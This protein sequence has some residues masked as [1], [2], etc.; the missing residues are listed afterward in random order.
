MARRKNVSK[1]AKTDPNPLSRDSSRLIAFDEPS[2]PIEQPLSSRRM[3]RSSVSANTRSYDPPS[4]DTVDFNGTPFSEQSAQSTTS[5][6]RFMSRVSVPAK[7]ADPTTK[8]ASGPKA[9]SRET[10]SVGTSEL[11][12]LRSA[13][14]FSYK[15]MMGDRSSHYE[16]PGTSALATPAETVLKASGTSAEVED[17]SARPKVNAAVRAQELRQSRYALASTSSKRKWEED[18]E[19]ELEESSDHRVARKLQAQLMREANPIQDSVVET[20]T[21]ARARARRSR[22]TKDPAGRRATFGRTYDL[23]SDSSRLSSPES[24]DTEMEDVHTEAVSKRTTRASGASRAAKDSAKKSIAASTSAIIEIGDSDDDNREI[25][26]LDSDEFQAEEAQN[27]EDDE[28]D[29]PT[30]VSVRPVPTSANPTTLTPLQRRMARAAARAARDGSAVAAGAII[31]PI[32]RSRGA[33][34]GH[35]NHIPWRARTTRA[36]R[37]RARLEYYHPEII[38]MWQTLEA[39]PVIPT[40][41]AEQPRYITR[42]LKPFQREGLNWMMQQEKTKWGGGL[43]GDEMGMGKTIQAVSLIMSDYPAKQPTLVVVPPVAL[44]Q[45]KNEIREYTSG[46]LQVLIYHGTQVK[47]VSIKELGRYNVIMTSY[48]T[49]ES[50]YRRQ[51]KGVKRKDEEDPLQTVLVKEDSPF[52]AIQFHRIILDEAHTIKSRQTGT[53]KAC[54]ALKAK[55]KW[56]LS[57]TPLQN[58]IGEF[59][60]LLRFLQV[61]PFAS[62]MCKTCSCTQLEWTLDMETHQCT[63]CNHRGFDHL[64]LF[65]M[66]L[67]NPITQHGHTGEGAEAF[68]KLRILMDRIMLRRDKA[69]H[70]TSMELPAKDV[71]IVNQFFGEVERDFSTSIMARTNRQFDTYVAQGVVLNHYANIFG[72]IMQMRQVANHPD[73]ILKKKAEGGQNV[74]VCCICDDPAEDAIRSSCHHDFCRACVKEHMKNCDDMNLEPAC[75][76]C[77]IPLAI[78]LEQE[79]REQDEDEVKKTSIINRIKMENWTSSTK[80]ETLMYELMMTR[81]MKC[82]LKVI[83]FSQFTSMLQLVEW[84]L[85]RAGFTTVLLDGAMSPSQRQSSIDFFMKNSECEIFLVSMKAGGVALNLTEASKVYILDPWWNPAAEWQSADRCHRI[86]QGRACDITRIVIEDSVESRMV[87]LQEKKANM[88]RGT[89]NG[90]VTAINKL[91]TE[92][93][94]FLFRGH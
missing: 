78:D 61:E 44:M 49:L 66:E 12:G 52:H 5:N 55:Y 23:L 43:L 28:E 27:S 3:T 34:R 15:S 82:R 2:T 84:R 94:Q 9:T 16:T 83:L 76:R 4:V 59:F 31:G 65:N 58:R 14:E 93:M 60:S 21:P 41:E 33:A 51:E 24:M 87:V 69:T 20:E 53:A 47:K 72:L 17:A 81:R 67:L 56:C 32:R 46:K 42:P 62:Y 10:H 63:S 90:D 13:S 8:K 92:D 80:I 50:M 29:E 79:E 48:P 40:A 11:A 7:P 37:T 30:I 19:D 75:P 25:I 85:R 89:I 73:L 86:G 45:W 35:P 36:E 6:R 70:A 39:T 38:T 22:F 64:S 54:F 71:G 68:R 1:K 74:L 57:G 91:T 18:T 88:I 26:D 77:H